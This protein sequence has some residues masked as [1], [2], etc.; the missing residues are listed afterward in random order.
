M[1]GTSA[2]VGQQMIGAELLKLRRNRT[3]VMASL[4]LTTG[5]LA[6]MLG[7]VAI[8]QQAG[9]LR[10]FENYLRLIGSYFGPL[11]AVLIGVEAGAGDVASGVFRDLVVTGRSRIALFLVRLPGALLLFLPLL[12]LSFAVAT[13]AA[14]AFAGDLPTPSA[15]LVTTY[16][17]WL[18]LSCGVTLIVS[19]GF[20]ALLGS[21]SVAT[22]A[23]IGWFAVASPLLTAVTPLGV[24]REALP[25][26]A[27]EHFKPGRV[28]DDL[29]PTS[30]VTAVVVLLAW[31]IVACAL[32]AWRT[33]TQD[34]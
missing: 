23:L 8:D 2:A 1:S 34:A 32:G 20:A 15:S 28:A 19:V 10:N 24:A 3:L 5:T 9:G 12:A 11:A 26:V 18:A 7:W 6:L 25:V 13:G 30:T 14:F 16:G 22:T 33:R 21:R 4:L 29:V 27:I 31:C 17:L